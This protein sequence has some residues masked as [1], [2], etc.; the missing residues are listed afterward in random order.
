MR[1]CSRVD[2]LV[3]TPNKGSFRLM[4]IHVRNTNEGT[5]T[6]GYSIECGSTLPTAPEQTQIHQNSNAVISISPNPM[7]NQANISW[8]LPENYNEA[9]LTIYDNLGRLCQTLPLSGNTGESQI[10]AN[11]LAGG[12]YIYRLTDEGNE[13]KQGKFIVTQHW[14]LLGCFRFYPGNSPIFTNFFVYLIVIRYIRWV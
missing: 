1:V 14:N 2:L 11:K 12:I 7:M 10:M 5:I 4:R 13:L 9:T 3:T 6:L 8:Q